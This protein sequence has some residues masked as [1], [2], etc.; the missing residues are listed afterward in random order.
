MS[1]YYKWSKLQTQNSTIL[2]MKYC[3]T[4]MGDHACC[5]A[6][7]SAAIYEENA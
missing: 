5:I 4:F 2:N 1:I 7:D 6:D 3:V